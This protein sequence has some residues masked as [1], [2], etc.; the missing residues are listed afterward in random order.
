MKNITK[1]LPHNGTVEKSKRKSEKEKSGIVEELRNLF[2][3]ELQNIYWVEKALAK[4]IPKMIRNAGGDLLVEALTGHLA[5]TK[6]HVT[7]LEEV[8][9]S[10]GKKPE[11]KKCK[12][13]SGLIKEAKAIMKESKRGMIRD[14]GIIAI[15]KKIEHY[16]IA[17]YGTL[18]SFAKTL[19]ETYTTTLLQNILDQETLADEKLSEIASFFTKAEALGA[20]DESVSIIPVA[21]SKQAQLV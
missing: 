20:N 6:E 1:K 21:V 7:R 8:F 10:I 18:C 15:A 13:V 2:V 3:D 12:T 19:G 9:Y 14:A 11:T 16:E 5:V 4:E 17:A